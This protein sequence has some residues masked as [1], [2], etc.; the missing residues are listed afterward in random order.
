MYLTDMTSC[1]CDA[2][3][4]SFLLELPL[5]YPEQSLGS[6]F[7]LAARYRESCPGFAARRLAAIPLL[8]LL[9]LV[10]FLLL[11]LPTGPFLDGC[12]ARAARR[13]MGRRGGE[14]R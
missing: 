14:S 1:P 2:A 5:V 8:F 6:F 4:W 11:L 13:L 3:P 12:H 10:L 9:R 7:G